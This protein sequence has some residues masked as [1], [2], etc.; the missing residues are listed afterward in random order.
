MRLGK[1]SGSG[2]KAGLL[3]TGARHQ[4]FRKHSANLPE[5]GALQ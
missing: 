1:Y 3:F 2:I 4:P 5:E